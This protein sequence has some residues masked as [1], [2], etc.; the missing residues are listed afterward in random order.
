MKIFFAMALSVF[1]FS[2]FAQR[3][4]KIIVCERKEDIETLSVILR[5]MPLSTRLQSYVEYKMVGPGG[6]YQESY[7]ARPGLSL[8]PAQCILQVKSTNSSLPDMKMTYVL[9][10]NEEVPQL[11]FTENPHLGLSDAEI[12]FPCT[13][14]DQSFLQKLK[15]QCQAHASLD[16]FIELDERLELDQSAIADQSAVKEIEAPLNEVQSARVSGQ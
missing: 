3:N 7:N 1:C 16:G 5:K 11:H 6:R 13:F 15:D 4:D 2:A 9:N 14:P 10:L 8:N 12:G